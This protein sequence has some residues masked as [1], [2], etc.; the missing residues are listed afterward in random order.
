LPRIG[1]VYEDEPIRIVV[2]RVIAKILRGP[3]EF[4]SL[5]GGSWPGIVGE[6]PAL[7]QILSNEHISRP[8][9]KVL[10]VVDSDR[11]DPLVREA[12]L[13]QKV[14]NRRYRFGAPIYHAISHQV[15]TWLL[16]DPQAINHAGG[17]VIP[18]TTDPE[19]LQDAKRYLVQLLRNHRAAPLDREFIRKAA[20]VLDVNTLSENCPR[21]G[22]LRRELQG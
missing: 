17:R 22:L 21:F 9:A 16:G 7:L 11:A 5:Q 1:L 6:T 4:R 19:S 8:F 20:E 10:V 14:G 15:E 3:T 13:R 18:A 2:E 12:R